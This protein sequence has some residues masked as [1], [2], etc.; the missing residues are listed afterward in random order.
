MKTNKKTNSNIAF[1]KWIAVVG[2]ILFVGKVIAWKLTNSDAVFSDAMESIVNVISAFL[3][4]YSLY[5]AAKPKDENH[6]YG[7]GKVEFVTSAI[8]GSLISIAGV[9]IIY[10]GTNSLISGK[11]LS[12]LDLGI[13]IIAATAIVNYIIGYISIRKGKREN[14][15]VLISSGKHLQSDTITTLGVVLSLVLVYFTK[16]IWLDSV[17]ALIFGFYIIILGY[18]IIRKSLSGIMDEADPEMLERLATFLN[19]NRKPE[20]IDIHNMKIQ[21]FGSRLHIDAHITLPWYFELRTAHNEMEEVIKLIAKNTDRKVEFNF[22][23]D[24]CK[25]TSCAICQ[26]EN[27]PVRQHIFTKKIDWNGENISQPDK[28]NS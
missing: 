11:V 17:V 28:H 22:H 3:G 4:L 18:K 26:V 9:M 12:K 16:L 6:P 15:I 21:Q 14:S 13:W 1:Q 10:E 23:M 8:E 19:E 5:L 25:P 24:D 20:W 2:I 7:H 27:C